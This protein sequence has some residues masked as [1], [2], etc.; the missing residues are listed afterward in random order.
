[1]PTYAHAGLAITWACRCAGR[2]VEEDHEKKNESWLV[3]YRSY[4]SAPTSA[5]VAYSRTH[6]R[7]VGPLPPAASDGHCLSLASGGNWSDWVGPVVR[8]RLEAGLPTLV[9]R[10]L[11]RQLL[12]TWLWDGSPSGICPQVHSVWIATG[13]GGAWSPILRHFCFL[14]NIWTSPCCCV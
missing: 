5:A 8:V 11:L 9:D 3:A 1:M 2:R 12:N 10:L 4:I 14:R 6:Y 13:T 7:A